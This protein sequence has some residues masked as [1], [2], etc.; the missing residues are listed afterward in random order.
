VK[1]ETE[2]LNRDVKQKDALMMELRRRQHI[3]GARA[4]SACLTNWHTRTHSD[5]RISFCPHSERVCARVLMAVVL[6]CVR[7]AEID[8]DMPV[9]AAQILELQRSLAALESEAAAQR[10]QVRAPAVAVRRAVC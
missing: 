5:R 6:V 8:K 10:K 4:A 1:L 3:V 7:A 2:Q 9:L